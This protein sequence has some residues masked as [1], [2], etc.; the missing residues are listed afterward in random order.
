MANVQNYPRIGEPNKF[1]GYLD[2]KKLT[3]HSRTIE[4]EKLKKI[5]EQSVEYANKKSSQLFLKFPK[6]RPMSKCGKFT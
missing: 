2:E 3:P 4:A 1:A 5:I 6:T